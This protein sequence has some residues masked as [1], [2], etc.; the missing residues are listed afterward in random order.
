MLAK[1]CKYLNSLHALPVCVGALLLAACASMGRP[2]GG[3]RDETPPMF[4]RSNPAPGS[5]NINTDRIVITFD[6]NVQVKDAM[7]KVVVS[8]PQESMPK[9]MGV[10][11]NVRV[12]LMD[13]LLPNTTYTIDFTD[14]ILDL[15]E[16]NELDGF[17]LSF[18]TGPTID[19][20]CISGMVFEAETLEPA[21]GMLVGLHSN[22]SD[23]ALTK[24]PFERVTRTNKL[25]QFTLR[26]L[27]EGTYRVFAINDINRD[28][29]WDRTEDIA[30]YTATVSPT[31][32]PVSVTDTLKSAAGKDSIVVR[33]ETEFLPND[34]LL[35]WFNEGYKRAYLSKYER[36][37]NQIYLEMGAP[38]DSMPQLVVAD[39][40]FAGRNLRDWAVIESSAH[41][42][43]ITYWLTDTAMIKAD[44]LLM[45]T[46]YLRTD[47]AD[48]LTWATDT[49]KFNMSRNQIKAEKKAAE[50]KNGDKNSDK[51]EN[52]N[53]NNRLNQQTP[54]P[55]MTPPASE[56]PSTDSLP[57]LPAD[58][59]AAD[60]MPP[61]PPVELMKVKI[62]NSPTLDVYSPLRILAEVPIERFNRSGVHL[63]LMVDTLWQSIDAPM[64]ALIDSLQPRLYEAPYTWKPGE[65]YK[66]TVDSASITD[67]YGLNNGPLSLEF[68]VKKLGEYSNLNMII[69]GVEGSAVAQL[70]D[71]QDK[72]V[73]SVA[74]EGG[75]AMF[76]HINPGDYYMRL[77]IDANSNGK[78]D[79]GSVAD[80]IQ[81]EET[82]YYPKRLTLKR[83]WDVEQNWDIFETPVDLQKPIDIKKNK[84]K[85]KPGDGQRDD[86]EEY[87]DQ[88]YDEFGNP[89]VDPNDPFGKRKNQR[90]NRL[91]SRDSNTSGMGAGYRTNG[92]R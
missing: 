54:P 89:S 59:L 65:K 9:V 33:Q 29:K 14:A 70:L 75:R 68:T 10:G 52:K 47:T 12:E 40:P 1:K 32:H 2:E 90:Y 35:T 5:T 87:D 58:S 84:P 67:I 31:S 63:E 25:G 49:L 48:H 19:S 38:L 92:L 4:V 62:D 30:F 81:P 82:Y 28:N 15:N 64:F 86:D 50:N 34:L 83:N 11:K 79:T 73:R 26:G 51:K 16:G 46:T 3:P 85:G 61:L 71:K 45:A 39:G 42:D 6:E 53:I 88:Y 22:L 56:S 55:A 24:V 72:P 43:T 44:S 18:A 78:W 66:L 36:R 74:V 80:S 69:T 17:S 57:N 23:T 77:F 60:T 27:K 37:R 7:N 8:P 91:N 21:Q 13:T 20:L 76:S 41:F